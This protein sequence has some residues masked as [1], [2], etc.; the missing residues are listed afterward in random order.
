MAAWTAGLTSKAIASATSKTT[1]EIL[2]TRSYF[3]RASI[4]HRV[5][6][7]ASLADPA[8]PLAKLL[9]ACLS[10]IRNFAHD[11]LYGNRVV[12]TTTNTLIRFLTMGAVATVLQQPTPF[13]K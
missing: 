9:L 6:R 12:R 3:R 7:E 8:A 10:V 2:V 13:A 11:V 1:G 4:V 5:T